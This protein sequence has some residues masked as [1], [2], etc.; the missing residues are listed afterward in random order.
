MLWKM[1]FLY[2]FNYW[3]FRKL[4]NLLFMFGC[5][6]L[7]FTISKTTCIRSL[8]IYIPFVGRQFVWNNGWSFWK[9]IKRCPCCE[10]L[11]RFYILKFDLFIPTHEKE[12]FLQKILLHVIYIITFW[13][14]FLQI[15]GW[16]HRYWLEWGYLAN[17]HLWSLSHCVIMY[18]P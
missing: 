10:N 3:S 6:S 9:P 8:N 11:G 7:L 2:S 17:K 14:F 1:L 18:T 13:L 4:S 15:V 16:Q 12:M 5:V